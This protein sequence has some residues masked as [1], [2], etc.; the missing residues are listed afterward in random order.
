MRIP[1]LKNIRFDKEKID[2]AIEKAL[3]AAVKNKIKGKEV[4]PFLLSEIKKITGGKSL[5]ANI[6][7]VLNNA[8]LA[9]EIAVNM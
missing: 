6:K 2:A 7:L 3:R 5:D 9:A 1:F 8:K 4:T